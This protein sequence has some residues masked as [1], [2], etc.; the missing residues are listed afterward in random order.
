MKSAGIKPIM[1]TGDNQRTAEAV[2]EEVGIERVI[3]N[4]QSRD[5]K[6]LCSFI[7]TANDHG[8]STRLSKIISE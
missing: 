7:L 2:A 6:T 1:I 5:W 3:A 4:L 8:E